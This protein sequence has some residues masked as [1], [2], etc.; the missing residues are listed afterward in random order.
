MKFSEDVG[1]LRSNLATA[2]FFP[3]QPG[4]NSVAVARIFYKLMLR[5][6]FREFYTQGG[7]WGSLI[8]TNMAQLVPR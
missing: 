8:C 4:L 7:D 3:S 2:L 1:N 6:G 5:L